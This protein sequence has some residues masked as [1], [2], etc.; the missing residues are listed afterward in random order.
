VHSCAPFQ[1]YVSPALCEYCESSDHDAHA[2][3]YLDYVDAI[4]ARIE[5]KINEMTDK[6]IENMKERIVKYSHCFDRSRENYSEPESSLGS[7]K[8]EVSPMIIFSP[9]INLGPIYN[10]LCLY[11]A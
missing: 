11:L 5:K 9:L 6:M 8:P 1:S 7:R 4:C 2:C 3:P 10:M